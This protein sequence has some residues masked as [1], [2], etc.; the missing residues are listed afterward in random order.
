[1]LYNLSEDPGETKDLYT[2]ERGIMKKMFSKLH[3]IRKENQKKLKKTL[4]KI[5]KDVDLEGRRK[6]TLTALKTLGYINGGGKNPAPE[7]TIPA[8]V[9]AIESKARK[10]YK[11]D[12]GSWEADYGDGII[13]VYIPS[14]KFTMGQT[15][16]EKNWLKEQDIE[17]I[18]SRH[19]NSERP[20]HTVYLDGYW[21]GKTEVTV[22]QFNLFVK[23]TGYVTEAESGGWAIIWTGKEWEEKEGKN[24]KKPGFK[25]EDNH[26]VVCVS[27]N[28]AV[29]YCKWL[30]SKTGLNFKL[31]TEARWE[32]AARWT[33]SRKY[34]WGGHEPYYNG[35]W[36][37]N[38]R[39]HDSMNRRGEDGFVFTAPVGSY[40]QGASSYGLLDIAGNV[41]EWCSDRYKFDYYKNSP[42]EDP[43]G[44]NIGPKRVMR[45]GSW[46][47]AAWGQRCAYRPFDVPS[48]RVNDVGFRLCQDN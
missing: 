12:K 13:M 33:D 31:P 3:G 2:I 5:G 26:P 6:E 45:G 37:A 8:D 11:N 47:Y 44:P 16:E 19:F 24:W 38:Y 35:Q 34:P 32:K 46:S 9:K 18:Y 20:L 30:S 14:G 15:N 4:A 29:K 22:K 10:I 21:I 40:P 36:Y 28:D 39:A 48:V 1:M 17:I 7:P 43:T 25:Q 23:D 27:W 41:W 42:K